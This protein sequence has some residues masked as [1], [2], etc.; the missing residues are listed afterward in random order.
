MKW[1]TVPPFGEWKSR[2]RRRMP[3]QPPHPL[4]QQLSSHFP[5][6]P[7]FPAA[8]RRV[9]VISPDIRG[10]FPGQ[11]L[12][13]AVRGQDRHL[14]SP[15]ACRLL[16]SLLFVVAAV[17]VGTCHSCL[18]MPC[19]CTAT[20]P[21]PSLTHGSQHASTPPHSHPCRGSASCA[22]GCR[23]AQLGIVCTLSRSSL[24]FT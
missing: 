21:F 13:C 5:P 8:V 15:R 4:R 1:W 14:P 18:D 3:L 10:A 19:I 20:P 2:R 16:P 11:W 23:T 12:L 6:P 22:W 9:W 17:A 24:L 7:P